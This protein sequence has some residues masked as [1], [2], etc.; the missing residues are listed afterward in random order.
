MTTSTDL[1]PRA[2]V[3]DDMAS[4]CRY[5]GALLSFEGLATD[6]VGDVR[7][8]IRALEDNVYDVVLLDLSLEAGES[9]YDVLRAIRERPD[10]ASTPV[11]IVT[12]SECE[13]GAVARGLRAGATDYITKPV[14]PDVLR[15]RVAASRRAKTAVQ[16]E[17]VSGLPGRKDF[18]DAVALQRACLP[19]VPCALGPVSIS[20]DVVP[21]AGVGGD[22]FDWVRDTNGSVAVALVD[23]AGHGVA[24]ALVASMIRAELRACLSNA[25]PLHV[26]VERVE[27]C[28]ADLEGEIGVTAAMGIVRLAEDGLRAEILNVGLPPIEVVAESG[29]TPFVSTSPP[30]GL[31]CQRPR[32][33]AEVA[34]ALGDTVLMMSDG[35]DPFA[36]DTWERPQLLQQLAARHGAALGLSSPQEMRRLIT[37]AACGPL[38]DDA[39]LVCIAVNR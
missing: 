39:T 4:N 14:D 35:L 17:S 37:E 15:A 13:P 9:G 38:A 8:A 18:D 32:M 27:R 11:I 26:V 36:A 28:L 24:A 7:S 29:V 10:M 21:L 12:G 33:P 3:V 1:P 5:L 30:V 16:V 25:L 20:G 6:S 2:L 34:L 31:C 19:R 23:V 22:F